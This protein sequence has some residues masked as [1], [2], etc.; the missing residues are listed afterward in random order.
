MSKRLLTPYSDDV[1]ARRPSTHLSLSRVGVT[2]VEKV[3]RIGVG[4]T[5]QLFYA[6]LECFVD[7]NPSQKGAHMS[8]FEE[9]V[10][11]AIEEVVLGEAF[12]A[13]TLA[14]HIAERVR[15]AQGAL[16]AEVTIAARY[17][18]EKTAPSSGAQTQEIYTLFGRAAASAA[19]TRRLV[20]VQAQGMTACPCAQEMV[21]ARSRDRLAEEGFSEEEILRI[22]EAVPVATHNQRGL[23]T[24]HIGCGPGCGNAIDAIELLEI[25]EESMSSEIFE[26]MKR[27]DEVEVV[28]KAHRHPRFVEDCVRESVRLAIERLGDRH[29]EDCFLLASQ[30]NLE[31]IHQHSVVA[32]REGLF[33]ELAGELASEEETVP[34]TSMREWLAS[35]S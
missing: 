24:L 28:E 9:K 18:E 22:L 34:H 2:G 32:E 17:P 13:E 35:R 6:E 15:D 31:T 14:A 27:S 10:N 4:D 11:E 12:K 20:G 25:V 7:L 5:E 33:G 21:A 19:G 1:Q 16:R 3:V 23:G 29:R 8:R 26:L 30:E